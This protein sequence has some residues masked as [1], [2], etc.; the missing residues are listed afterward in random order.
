MRLV[1]YLWNDVRS[2]G[3]LNGNRVIDLPSSA[4][5]PNNMV[6]FLER[7]DEAMSE[8]YAI[9][10]EAKSE[11]GILLD[12]ITY[13]P[14]VTNPEKVL[15]LGK[16]YY[17]H[18]SEMQSTPPSSPLLF[19]KTAGSL[20]AHKG[21]IVIPAIAES[22]DYEAELAVIIGKPCSNVAPEDV[23]DYIAGYAVA[24]D[25][26]ARDLQRSTSQFAAGKMPDTFGPLGP[27]L[28]TK[29]EVSDVANLRI[30]A[31]L[32]GE[33]MQDSNTSLLIFDIPFTISYIS[34]FST[35]KPGDVLFTGTPGGVGIARDPQVLL[36]SG[37]E[38]KVVIDQI[39]TL[40]NT[41]A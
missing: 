35:L 33:V 6:A 7:G 16:N 11:D 41:V 34:Q 14:V 39:G 10:D 4:D 22:V 1:S 12:E 38:I 30:Q 5:L 17:A 29:D 36:K 37:D 25:V 9:L 8:A 13:L 3:V 19:N 20:N 21:E 18:I 32:N 24:N 27:T 2:I 28:V 40:T 31:I 26:T 15:C 23:F